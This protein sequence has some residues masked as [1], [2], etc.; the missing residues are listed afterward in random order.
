M[1]PSFV[2]TA[3]HETDRQQNLALLKSQ[4]P[5]LVFAEAIYPS[6]QR[7][8]FLAQLQALSLERTGWKLN[9]GEIGVLLSNRK[10]WRQI[11]NQAPDDTTLYLVLESDSVVVDAEMLR[12]VYPGLKGRY[13]LFFWG[14]WSGH[15]QLERSSKEKINKAYTLGRPYIKTVYGAYGYCINRKAALYL[16]KKTARISHPVD[17]YKYF[18]QKG[19]IAI[20]GIIPEV[21]THLT[22]ESTI[23]HPVM[24]VWRK[25]LFLKILDIKNAL[26]CFFK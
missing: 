3:P 8:P 5:E 17:Q 26:T 11:I 21:I 13:D 6:K 22:N 24:P 7:I 1:I 4:L 25:K 16:L 23:G 12:T 18:I 2:I 10:I 20:G 9:E 14:A 19:N 15:M